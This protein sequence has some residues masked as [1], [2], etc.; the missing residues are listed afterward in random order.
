[1]KNQECKACFSKIKQKYYNNL[2]VE[3]YPNCTEE[4][5]KIASSKFDL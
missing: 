4:E 1:M 3:S 2:N 5:K